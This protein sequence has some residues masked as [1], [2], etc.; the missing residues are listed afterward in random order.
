MT[1][2]RKHASKHNRRPLRS[3]DPDYEP[4][5][6]LSV[7]AGDRWVD[8]PASRNDGNLDLTANDQFRH[9]HRAAP[10]SSERN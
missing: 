10:Y 6:L 1:A 5:H 4:D 3:D 2:S 9:Y 8:D 7:L